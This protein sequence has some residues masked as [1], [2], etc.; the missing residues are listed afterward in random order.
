MKYPLLLIL[1]LASFISFAQNDLR[2]VSIES[3]PK[4][5]QDIENI[6]MAVRWTDSL[7]DNVLVT[8]KNTGR[9]KEGVTLVD[10]DDI[11]IGG[12]FDRRTN[13]FVP[14]NQYTPPYSTSNSMVLPTFTYHFI[15]A[16][17]SSAALIWKTMGVTKVCDGEDGS[18]SKQWFVITDIDKDSKAEIWLISKA[19]CMEDETATI[20]KIIMYENEV[21]YPVSDAIQGQS[22]NTDYFNQNFGKYSEQYK[23]YAVQL[24]NK[25]VD[26]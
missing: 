15:I 4:D 19:I 18:H 16:K 12:T 1:T 26:K 23:N 21:L 10:K 9:A 20:M 11:R 25:F 8:T 6:S 22:I 17:D 24:W 3:L 7:G 5:I 2:R 14:G 13:K